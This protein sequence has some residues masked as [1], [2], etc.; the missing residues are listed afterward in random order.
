MPQDVS[1]L[2]NI[3]NYPADKV[4]TFRTATQERRQFDGFVPTLIEIGFLQILYEGRYLWVFITLRLLLERDRRQASRRSTRTAPVL[5]SYAMNVLL[6]SAPAVHVVEFAIKA[7]YNW[8]SCT[9]CLN[10]YSTQ[11][12]CSLMG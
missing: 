11:L 12:L 8:N 6:S 9:I 7:Y 4:Q 3:F 5:P 2:R 1:F 10:F